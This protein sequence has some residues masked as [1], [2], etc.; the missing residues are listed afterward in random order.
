MTVKEQAHRVL[1]KL[2]EDAT[3]DD[4]VYAFYVG[5]RIAQGLD[6]VEKGRTISDEEVRREFLK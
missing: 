4:V 2:P 1:D 6:D 3:W 5:Q